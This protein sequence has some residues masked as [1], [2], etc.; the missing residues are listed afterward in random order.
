MIGKTFK[1]AF[2][3]RNINEKQAVDLLAQI[4]DWAVANEA[5]LSAGYTILDPSNI[6][7]AAVRVAVP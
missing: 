1:F 3:V 2:T 7:M 6:D 4:S 5:A